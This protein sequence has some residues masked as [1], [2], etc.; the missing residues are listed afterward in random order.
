[1]A[2][3]MKDL[4]APTAM[5]ANKT[6]GFAGLNAAETWEKGSYFNATGTFNAEVSK[7]KRIINDQL[8]K[9]NVIIEL[10]IKEILVDA[11]NKAGLPDPEAA[12]VGE[13]KTIV[14]DMKKRAMAYSTLKQF[15]LAVLAPKNPSERLE[16]EAKC[17]AALDRA[18]GDEQY[19]KGEMIKLTILPHVTQGGAGKLIH[20]PKFQVY[21]T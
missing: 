15:V 12:R 3:D 21:G 6:S 4:P 13:K 2:L 14:V 9:D 10:L 5:P 7:V 16:A 18:V 1:M 11:P 8:G 19:F 20:L 17:E